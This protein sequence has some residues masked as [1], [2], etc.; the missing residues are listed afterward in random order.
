[1]SKVFFLTVHPQKIKGNWGMAHNID[2][3]QVI[4]PGKSEYSRWGDH[5]EGF[6]HQAGHKYVIEVEERPRPPPLPMD[7]SSVTYHLRK[8]IS[9]ELA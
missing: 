6:N 7:V 8:V 5:I 3:L 9:D 1:M 4:S 2:L